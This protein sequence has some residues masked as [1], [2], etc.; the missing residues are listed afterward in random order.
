MPLF[1][2]AVWNDA[3][4]YIVPTLAATYAVM[5]SHARL[6]T[7]SL[8]FHLVACGFMLIAVGLQERGGIAVA[9]TLLMDVFLL[10]RGEPWNGRLRGVWQ[11]R[12]PLSALLA[13]VAADAIIWR[14]FYVWPGQRQANLAIGAKV[15][16]SAFGQYLLP[17]FV[18]L[19]T[20]LQGAV[21]WIAAI[22][23]LGGIIFVAWRDRRALDLVAFFV[24]TFLLYYVGLLFSPELVNGVKFNASAA[25]YLVYVTFP[26][27]M[28]LRFTTRHP[29]EV[30]D[31]RP[32]FSADRIVGEVQPGHDGRSRLSSR[33]ASPCS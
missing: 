4:V 25:W 21:V 7:G 17:S 18:G 19:H 11:A 29:R 24:L 16:S 8:R 28:S 15:V 26:L 23:A 2:V 33:S 10:G 27:L 22:V 14:L 12:R 31:K 6:R 9:L 20:P 13:I 3:A 32:G 30:R 5:A 1:S